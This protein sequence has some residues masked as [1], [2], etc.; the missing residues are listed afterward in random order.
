MK[1]GLMSLSQ[2]EL[3]LAAVGATASAFSQ[4]TLPTSAWDSAFWSWSWPQG[5]I[6]DLVK[7]W[8]KRWR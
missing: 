4:A 6:W 7:S 3:R 5:S 2:G 8:K 1:S